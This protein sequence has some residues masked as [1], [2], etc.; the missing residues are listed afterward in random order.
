MGVCFKSVCVCV[1]VC[2]WVCTHVYLLLPNQW[3]PNLSQKTWVWFLVEVVL[4]LQVSL[5]V[6]K[7]STWQRRRPKRHGFNPWSWRSPGGGSCNPLQYSCL[8]NSI[9]KKA[10]Q[11]TVHGA[12]KSQTWLSNWACTHT[13]TH[14]HKHRNGSLEQLLACAILEGLHN[15]FGVQLPY[16]PKQMT[17]TC[18]FHWGVARIRTERSKFVVFFS[19]E[20]CLRLK[21]HDY[22]DSPTC[23]YLYNF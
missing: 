3:Q 23:T 6:N 5:V 11:A 20:V 18:L 14:T 9:S 22:W 19:V 1:C 21:E 13:H 4:S 12:S 7:K 17:Q 16:L 15:L 2:V 10:W 8:E